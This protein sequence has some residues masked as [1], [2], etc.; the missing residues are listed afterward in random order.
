LFHIIN[1]LF[2]LNALVPGPA[3]L[4]LVSVPTWTGLDLLIMSLSPEPPTEFCPHDH[5]VPSV[6]NAKEGEPVIIDLQFSKD[7]I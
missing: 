7:P 1:P 3:F 6:F 4:Q 2:Y 5:S